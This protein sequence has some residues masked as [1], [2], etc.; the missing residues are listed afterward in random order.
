MTSPLRIIQYTGDLTAAEPPAS[1]AV[2]TDLIVIITSLLCALVCVVGLALVARFASLLR[3]SPAVAAPESSALLVQAPL[4][5]AGTVNPGITQSI[6]RSLPT[7]SFG[8]SSSAG[9]AAAKK[10]AELCAICLAEFMDGDRVRVLPQCGHGFHAVCVDMWLGSHQSCPSCRRILVVP[11][12]NR[13]C[14]DGEPSSAG[15]YSPGV[16]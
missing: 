1:V 10:L 14:D 2:D 15:E 6:L 12:S 9:A 7:L 8:S 3:P 4:A 13:D 11:P 16:P 5:G